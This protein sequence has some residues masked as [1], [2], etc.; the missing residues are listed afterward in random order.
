MGDVSKSD[1]PLKATFKVRLNGETVTLATVGQ[2]YRFISNLS[3]V[4]WMEFRS[5]HDEALVALERAAGNAMLT[6]QA[7]NALRM[8]FVRAKLL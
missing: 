6:V 5:L 1:T 3:A 4:E 2:A 7:T 8:L